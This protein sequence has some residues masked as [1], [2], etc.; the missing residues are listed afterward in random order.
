[1]Y[2]GGASHCTELKQISYTLLVGWRV[3]RLGLEVEE[4]I[5]IPAGSYVTPFAKVTRTI[6]LEKGELYY[7]RIY[8]VMEDGLGSGYGECIIFVYQL[9][10]QQLPRAG[11]L[12]S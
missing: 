9:L 3:D 8:D 7:F 1:V 5:R 2:H 12:N 10:S 4:I 6:I 11:F